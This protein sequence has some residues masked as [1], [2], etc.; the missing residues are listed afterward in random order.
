M[1]ET[2][3]RAAL[4][5]ATE[6][7]EPRPDLLER[8][9]AGARRRVV[10][11]YVTMAAAVVSV[12]AVTAVGALAG[13]RD[14][15]D[16]PA[17]DPTPSAPADPWAEYRGWRGP[18]PLLEGPTRGDLAHD[19]A[20]LREA[21]QRWR[22]FDS[23][24]TLTGE[25]HV[26][27]A[28]TTPA[29]KA[30]FIA[31]R[32]DNPESPVVYGHLGLVEPGPDGR[33]VVESYAFLQHPATIRKPTSML[34]G[35][36]RDVLVVLDT[37]LK[38]VTYS[39]DF[40]YAPDGTVTRTYRPVTYTDGAAVIR[41]PA[42]IERY[43]MALKAPRVPVDSPV[44]ADNVRDSLAT[45]GPAGGVQ[46]WMLPE[47]RRTDESCRL[48][49]DERFWD[50]G[51]MHPPG[52]SGEWNITARTPDGRY[53]CVKTYQFG[54]DP[55]RVAYGIGTS[56]SPPP[57]ARSAGAAASAGPLAVRLRLPG[58]QGVIVG[59]EDASLRY[60]SGTGPWQ[61]VAGSVAL[62][63]D[64]ATAV[65]VIRKGKPAVRVELP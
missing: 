3:V 21:V 50:A 12:M 14:L 56:D 59:A 5:R 49:E 58:G 13:P 27:W 10:R 2:T 17:A 11:R 35:A 9:H 23:G 41:L 61:A 33:P 7:L 16:R 1:N 25:P 29:G 46:Y 18:Y 4:D 53:V 15:A 24:I 47:G 63:P 62:L 22:K 64:S 30:A 65:Q 60:R 43:T 28:G 55:R 44:T 36:K 6:D 34:L 48:A 38:D 54:S 20:F 45:E 40:A 26:V 8:V 37:G 19:T 42:Q 52:S 51:A 39:T 57:V 31:Q 32:G